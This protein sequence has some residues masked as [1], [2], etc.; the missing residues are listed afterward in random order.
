MKVNTNQPN[1]PTET[2]TH[3]PTHDL[4]GPTCTGPAPT[5]SSP[6]GG[7]VVNMAVFFY[8]QA[9]ADT[10]IDSMAPLT[11]ASA[12][13]KLIVD[14]YLTMPCG[15]YVLVQGGAGLSMAQHGAMGHS[16]ATACTQV[17]NAACTQVDS[18]F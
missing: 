18:V 15:S 14:Q 12:P 7:S 9:D 3:P 17:D 4:Q 10:F 16:M 6:L 8:Y 2:P 13:M 1:Q 5:L 11:T